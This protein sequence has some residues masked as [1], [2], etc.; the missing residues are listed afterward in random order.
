MSTS[1]TTPLE[2]IQGSSNID[3]MLYGKLFDFLKTMETHGKLK[4]S[5]NS[6]QV[7]LADD[8]YVTREQMRMNFAELGIEEN[9]VVHQDGA[10]VVLYFE[11]LLKSLNIDAAARQN[12]LPLQ[13][14][15]LLLLDINMPILTGIEVM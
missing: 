9:L 6:G 7:V 11:E 5:E 15:T 2:I 12:K 14:V 13:P 3:P 4:H 1:L 10:A 8:Q